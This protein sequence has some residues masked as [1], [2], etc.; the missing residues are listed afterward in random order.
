MIDRVVAGGWVITPEAEGVM[1]IG[2]SGEQIAYV[3][4][5]NEPAPEGAEIIDATGMVVTPGGYKDHVTVVGVGFF[6]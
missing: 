5:R 4:P 1:D 2:I 3:G 6:K